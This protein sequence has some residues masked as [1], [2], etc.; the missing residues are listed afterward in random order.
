MGFDEGLKSGHIIFKYTL[1]FLAIKQ[2]GE[3]VGQLGADAGRGFDRVG[4]LGRVGCGERDQRRS[5]M[6][7]PGLS[8]GDADGRMGVQQFTCLLVNI[9]DDLFGLR[10]VEPGGIK[11]IAG[12]LHLVG[13]DF[14]RAGFRICVK[15][16]VFEKIVSTQN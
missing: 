10:V 4:K 14:K 5:G 15:I 8:G 7:A 1:A 6:G 11:Q 13:A 16:V 2:I 3:V 12:R 9:I